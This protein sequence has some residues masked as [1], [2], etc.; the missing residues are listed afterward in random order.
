MGSGMSL[1]QLAEQQ[2]VLRVESRCRGKGMR[3]ARVPTDASAS[4]Q[5]RWG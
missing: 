5:Q 3:I 4:L 1:S 2:G